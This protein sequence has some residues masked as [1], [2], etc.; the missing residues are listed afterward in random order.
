LRGE[1]DHTG[2]RL[3][4]PEIFIS[5]KHGGESEEVADKLFETG[6]AKGYNIVYDKANLEYKGRT[7]EFMQRIGWGRY[8]IIIISDGYLKSEYCMFE[9][10][11]IMSKAENLEDRSFPIVLP[12]ADIFRELNRK[13]YDNY[14]KDEIEKLK[15]GLS[16]MGSDELLKRVAAIRKYEKIQK[17]IPKLM[18]FFDSRN[19]LTLQ[20]LRDDHF[21]PIFMA[22]DKKIE[23]DLS[24]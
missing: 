1:K 14:W 18:E 16:E 3:F 19:S 11:E 6:N 2:V 23:E 20:K 22:L 15:T 17:A 8:V 5:Y 21:N 9:F 7:W 4:N 10:M 13:K 12:D 24:I